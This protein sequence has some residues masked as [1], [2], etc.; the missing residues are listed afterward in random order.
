MRLEM[1]CPR[2]I[3]GS[4]AAAL[5]NRSA[6]SAVRTGMKT[7]L[8]G[9]LLAVGTMGAT[10]A[11]ADWARGRGPREMPREAPRGAHRDGHYEPRTQQTWVPGQM[12][13]VWEPG[14]C[15][16]RH[17]GP[18]RCGPGHYRTV[19]TPGHYER[20]TEWVWVPNLR[21]PRYGLE[22]G[23]RGPRGAVVVGRY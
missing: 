17:W 9:L 13:Q 22:V 7:T 23:W 18:P 10:T 19:A 21:G 8:L 6:G 1:T 2:I 14:R 5:L 3:G 4:A 20:Y 11:H 16:A 12:Q 15:V